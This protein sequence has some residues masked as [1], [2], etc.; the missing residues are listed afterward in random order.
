MAAIFGQFG[1]TQTGLT[2]NGFFNWFNLAATEEDAAGPGETTYRPTGDSFHALVSLV[3]QAGPT[4][5]LQS[6]TLSVARSFIDD[7]R[8][9]SF[10]RDIIKSFLGA[11][12]GPEDQALE[13]IVTEIQFRDAPGP[14]LMRGEPPAFSARPSAAFLVMTGVSATAA[15]ELTRVRLALANDG[16]QFTIRAEPGSGRRKSWL[17]RLLGR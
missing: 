9:G 15:I 11:I 7:R 10:A 6:L 3:S 13:P 14:I 2:D 1:D 4:G 5:A 8:Q 16:A 17:A 12:A